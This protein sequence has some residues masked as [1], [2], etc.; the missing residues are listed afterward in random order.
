MSGLILPRLIIGAFGSEVNGL[1]SSITQFLSFISL[2]EGGLGAV[3]LAELYGPIEEQD[4]GRV[5][6]IL[7]SCQVFFRKLSLIFIGYTAIISIVYPLFVAERFE[8]I[9]TFSLVWILS[10]TTLAQYLFSITNKLLLQAC[11]KIY[12]VNL[13]MTTT[14]ILN[15]IIA[16]VLI[17]VYPEIHII[18]LMAA[19]AYLIQPILYKHF[20]DKKYSI[21]LDKRKKPVAVVLKNRWSGFAQNLAYFININTDVAILTV[22]AGL[23]EVSIYTVH[24]LA[25]TAL[26]SI[27]ISIS[28][29]YQSALGKYYAE[30]NRVALKEKFYKFEWT[31]WIIGIVVFSTCMILLNSF[32]QIYTT[33]VQDTDY[34]KPIFSM[35]IVIANMIYCIKE[36]YRLLVLA[37]GK[38]KE[39]NFGA[40]AEAV[41]NLCISFALVWR[42]GLV[43]VAIGTLL[44]TLYSLFYYISFLKKDVL[45]ISFSHY[46][47]LFATWLVMLAMNIFVYFKYPIVV[48]TIVTFAL[49][50]GLI[51]VVEVLVAVL[52]FKFFERLQ[53][54]ILTNII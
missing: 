21:Q 28:N 37:M 30:G 46:P 47:K 25:V 2:L 19:V 48:E 54:R 44:A 29:S 9:Y 45:N 16:V 49:Y 24:M 53:K 51:L 6:Q 31:F 10:F 7:Y 42:L 22:F 23:T 18:K 50:G 8:F 35:L 38:F 52:V 40:V 11:Q 3:V 12:I 20:I 26:R 1:N 36:P 5:K 13:V 33:G 14:V 34:Y 4:V 32:V 41:I 39:T 17:Y 27:I 15:L 43:G